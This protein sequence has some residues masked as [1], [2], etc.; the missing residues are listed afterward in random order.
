MNRQLQD[1]GL[2]QLYID[3]S[4]AGARELQQD[5][6]QRSMKHCLPFARRLG[7]V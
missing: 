3:P 5:I 4:K 2:T 6:R 1:L 7:I